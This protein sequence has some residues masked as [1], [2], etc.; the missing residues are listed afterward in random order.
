M[1]FFLLY[2]LGGSVCLS[3][4]QY[5]QAQTELPIP[6]LPSIPDKMFNVKDFGAKGDN[7]TDNTEAIQ[8]AIN[9]ATN[10]GGGKVVIS[11]GIYLCGPLQFASNLALQID[12]TAILKMLALDKY[13]GGTAS[14]T[15][16]IFGSKLHDVAIIGKG[17]IDGKGSPWWPFAKEKGAKRPR[18]I[19]LRE[20]EK[21][22]I[23]DVTLTNSPMFHIAISG[24]SSN[25]TVKGVIV[26]APAS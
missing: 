17:T 12:S 15:D 25:V 19:A 2:V 10:A 21:V 11:P 7:Q 4:F 16:F 3:V 8:K 9:A 20:C 1:K 24:K 5:S 14:G 6:T 22:L 13:P 26:R 23:Q 18:M